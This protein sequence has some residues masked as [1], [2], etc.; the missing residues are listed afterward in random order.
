MTCGSCSAA[1]SLSKS[2][3][4]E[5]MKLR[6]ARAARSRDHDARRRRRVAAAIQQRRSGSGG[7]A[8]SGDLTPISTNKGPSPRRARSWRRDEMALTRDWLHV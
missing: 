5:S 2:I 3:E 8:G 1:T 7:G 4:D 6:G